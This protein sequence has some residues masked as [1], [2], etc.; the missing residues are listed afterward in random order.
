MFICLFLFVCLPTCLSTCLSIYLSTNL[1]TYPSTCLSSCL[2]SCLLTCLLSVS[3]PPCLPIY[4]LAACMTPLLCCDAPKGPWRRQVWR[5]Q[6]WPVTRH[7]TSSPLLSSPHNPVRL[8][9]VGSQTNIG[10]RTFMRNKSAIWN[11]L[12]ATT[13]IWKTSSCSTQLRMCLCYCNAACLCISVKLL[14]SI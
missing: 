9:D 13:W 6:A 2:S 1:F 10:S 8:L 14:W 7:Y 3:L 4:I 12:N 11:R 5:G